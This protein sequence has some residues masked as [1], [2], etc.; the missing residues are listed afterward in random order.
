MTSSPSTIIKALLSDGPYCGQVRDVWSS[1]P[2]IFFFRAA[3]NDQY[4]PVTFGGAL[5]DY[6]LP[7]SVVIYRRTDHV[8]PDGMPIYQWEPPQ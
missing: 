8:S 2:F 1:E 7:L 5:A 6:Q 3:L 4:V